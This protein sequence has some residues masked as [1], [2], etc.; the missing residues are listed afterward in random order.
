MYFGVGFESG[1][2]TCKIV[3]SEW[4][5]REIWMHFV[6]ANRPFVFGDF[7]GDTYR[8]FSDS[9]TSNRTRKSLE[10]VTM[11]LLLMKIPK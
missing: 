7:F 10:I 4:Q 8:Q 2:L 9:R 3:V 6:S 5:F 1:Q 11:A